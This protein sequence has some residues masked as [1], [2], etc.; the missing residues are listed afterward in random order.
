VVPDIV[1]LGKPMGNGHPIGAVVTTPEIAGSFKTGMEYFNTYGGNPVSCAVGLAVLDVIKEEGLQENAR[2]VG[3]H[4]LTGLRKLKEEHPLVG[5]VRGLG[6]YIGVELVKEPK[7]RIPATA[8]ASRLKERLREFHFLLSTDGPQENVLKIK[9][10][11]VFSIA[12]ADRLLETMG[13]VL[14]EEEFNL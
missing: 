10:P 3:E 9:P 6:L 4:L 13:R 2:V 11:L 7:A 8:Q 5:D 14:Q 12:D 1:T